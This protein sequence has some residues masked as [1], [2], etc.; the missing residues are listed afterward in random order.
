MY[1]LL[2][3]VASIKMKSS[4][5]LN[6][7]AMC[8]RWVLLVLWKV[9]DQACNCSCCVVGVSWGWGKWGKLKFE[10]E[11]WAGRGGE[12]RGGDS[13][14]HIQTLVSFLSSLPFCYSWTSQ[15][16]QCKMLSLK[17]RLCHLESFQFQC[18]FEK[19]VT[20]ERWSQT[21]V[22]LCD[23]IFTPYDFRVTVSWRI[24]QKIKNDMFRFQI[25]CFT[26]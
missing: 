17:V 5:N 4:S 19:L 25:I 12:G 16:W 1:K 14:S 15:K 24:P 13:I 8:Q 22:W 18:C 23:R 21:E 3:S 6:R 11:A 7:R 20:E 10:C 9:T 26:Q 2:E